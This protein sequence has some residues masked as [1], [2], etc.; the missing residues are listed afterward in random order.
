[1]T[2]RERVSRLAIP[3]IGAAL[4]ALGNPAAGAGSRTPSRR[5]SWFLFFTPGTQPDLLEA[6]RTR[7]RTP[8]TCPVTPQHRPQHPYST[9]DSNQLEN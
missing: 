5:W 4:C 9:G 7:A 6:R 2:G 1:M 8:H 3:P